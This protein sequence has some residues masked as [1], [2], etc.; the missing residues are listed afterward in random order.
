[1]LQNLRPAYAGKVGFLVNLNSQNAETILSIK[2]L[3]LGKKQLKQEEIK[4]EII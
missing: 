4:G 2:L 1:M 3:F